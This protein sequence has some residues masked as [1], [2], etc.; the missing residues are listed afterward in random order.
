MLRF[1]DEKRVNSLDSPILSRQTVK[2]ATSVSEVQLR[3]TKG[4]ATMKNALS[5][6]MTADACSS[7]HASSQM[8]FETVSIHRAHL[9][10]DFA[11]YRV[12]AAGWPATSNPAVAGKN[13]R[14]PRPLGRCGPLGS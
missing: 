13:T 6:V 3:R 10:S 2:A 9:I 4:M 5:T 12:S 7:S 11:G 8:Q 1:D 14:K